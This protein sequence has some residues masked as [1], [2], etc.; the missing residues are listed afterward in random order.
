LQIENCVSIALGSLSGMTRREDGPWIDRT[1]HSLSQLAALKSVLDLFSELELPIKNV[2]SQDP[3]FNTLDTEFLESIGLRVVH[4]PQ[5]F[6]LINDRTFFFCPG[7]ERHHALRA[8]E[9]D[10]ALYFG[11]ELSPETFGPIIESFRQKGLDDA[12]IIKTYLEGKDAVRLL[13]FEPD[14]VALGPSTFVYARKAT[15]AVGEAHP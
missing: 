8:L 2:Y 12:H 4:S 7:A 1:R 5:A 9:Y 10:P 6:C 3:V 15:T 13:D 11:N 14:P